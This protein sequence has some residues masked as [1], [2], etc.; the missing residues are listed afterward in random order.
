MHQFISLNEKHFPNSDLYIPE[1][2][3]RDNIDSD[4]SYKKGHPFCTMHFG[5]GSRSCVGRRFAEL[6]LE[7]AVIN[8]MR[9]FDLSWE[10]PRPVRKT[11]SINYLEGPYN[12]IF[13]NAKM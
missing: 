10:G 13:E 7:V 2:W 5:F 12:F 8:F 11:T 9:H 3:L 1:R 4:I 6:E